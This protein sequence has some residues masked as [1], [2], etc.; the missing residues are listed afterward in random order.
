MCKMSL[1]YRKVIAITAWSFV[2]MEYK[3]K[4]QYIKNIYI[5]F[6][7]CE[8]PADPAIKYTGWKST[9]IYD[10]NQFCVELLG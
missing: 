8:G 10:L 7:A 2:I 3:R 9:K 4:L 6:M 1:T 5:Y